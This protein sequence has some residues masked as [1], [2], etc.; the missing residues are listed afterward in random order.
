MSS[1]K[2]KVIFVLGPPG[3]GKG[4]ICQRLVNKFEFGHYSAGD[5]LRDESML[6]D[7][8][9]GPLIK[10]YMKDGKI[11]PVEISCSLIENAMKTSGKSKFL[12]D[13]FPRNQDNVDGWN[14]T[15]ADK[16][17][18]QF[19]LFF[20]CSEELCIQRCLKRGESSGRSDDNME[21]LKKR[22]ASHINDSLPIIEIYK[23]MGKVITIDA[24]THLEVM[25]KEVE[26]VVKNL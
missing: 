2:P 20:D 25:Y 17:D 19:V 22:I 7:S 5:L 10:E 1:A 18:F 3:A 4:T 11:V 26:D 9:M 24:S 13:G 6:P 12:I 21:T 14:R 23:K 16:V 15:M 8:K